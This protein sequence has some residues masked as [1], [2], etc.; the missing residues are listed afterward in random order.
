VDDVPDSFFTNYHVGDPIDDESQFDP[1]QEEE[2]S[3]TISYDLGLK[4]QKRVAARAAN[5]Q[6]RRCQWLGQAVS[7]IQKRL[8]RWNMGVPELGADWLDQCAA[9]SSDNTTDNGGADN[10]KKVTLCH[11]P[12]GDPANAHTIVVGVAAARAHLAQGDTLGACASN[13]EPDGGGEEPDTTAPVISAV[14]VTAG[15][16]SA[17]VAW[18]TDEYG[19]SKVEFATSALNS[20]DT[21]KI[22]LGVTSTTSHFVEL[23][24]LTASTTYYYIVKST[25]EAGNLATST[26]ATFITAAEEPTPKPDTTAPVISDVAVETHATSAVITWTTD[27]AADS[28]ATYADE[29][30]ATASTTDEVSD[31]TLTLSHSLDL[32]N[33][34]ASTTYYYFVS[35]TDEAGN[36]AA[37][38][39]ATFITTAE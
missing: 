18:I 5:I 13:D 6:E 15:T 31:T 26:E 28:V 33:L 29:P 39:E 20:A 14:S 24:G 12:K 37:S 17:I 4:A 9:A 32:V 10:G 19:D 35:S 22:A 7:K 21:V 30:T 11:I 8:T 34:T 38:T 3:P 16:D 25:D 36:T 2:E 1:D 23:S 27:E